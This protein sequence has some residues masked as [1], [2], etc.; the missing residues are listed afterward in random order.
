MAITV[1]SLALIAAHLKAQVP[2]FKSI[3]GAA[4]LEN[5]IKGRIRVAPAG[6]VIPL[7]EDVSS[8]STGSM[9]VTQEITDRFAIAYA[10][11]DLSGPMGEEAID[12]D[13]RDLRLATMNALVG[14]VPGNGFN[15]CEYDGGALIQIN[16]GTIIWRDRFRTSHINES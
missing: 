8:N 13:L 11:K 7:N 12:G 16:G 9:V 6:F 10:V 2:A 14:W 5:A 3:E 1:L 4:E 15:I